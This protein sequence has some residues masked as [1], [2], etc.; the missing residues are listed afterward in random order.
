MLIID[1][2]YGEGGGQILRTALSLS[3]ILQKPFK[4]IKI[5][6]GRQKPGLQPQHLACVKAS[7]IISSAI[8]EGDTLHSQELIFIPQKKPQKE[9]YTFDIGTAGSTS[10]LLQTLFYP[11]SF[12]EGATLYL[13]G[14]THVPHSPTYHY[15][16]KVWLPVI[17]NFGFRGNLKLERPGFYPQGEG[18]VFS[19]IE[20]KEKLKLPFLTYGFTPDEIEILSFITDNLPSHILERQAKS[21]LTILS[22]ENLESKV[23]YETLKS[24]SPGTMLF[25]TATDGEKRAGFSTLGKKGFPAEE[26]GKTSALA[27][28]KFLETKTQFEEH[29][30]DQLL[31]PASL[32]LLE[33][34]SSKFSYTVSC[35]T[36]HLLTQG[37]LIPQFLDKI[38]IRIEGKLKEKGEVF[39]ER[40]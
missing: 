33:S 17:K 14:G 27:F 28:L 39:L 9:T 35:I 24:L 30:G 2:S 40:T 6:A 8:T 20:K 32:A 34:P 31:L 4:I 25:I 23:K 22:K 21:A 37:W 19:Q 36:M 1:G 7:K 16:E 18:I 38:K 15:L 12:S 26:V 11:L 3:L 29:L 13:K 5:R 10:L